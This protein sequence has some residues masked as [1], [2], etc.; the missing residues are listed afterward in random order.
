MSQKNVMPVILK[1]VLLKQT[2]VPKFYQMKN[3]ETSG[4]CSLP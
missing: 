3:V 2:I 4:V 1:S